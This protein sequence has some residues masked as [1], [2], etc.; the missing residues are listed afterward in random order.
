MM[1]EFLKLLLSLSISGTILILFLFLLKGFMKNKVSKKWQYYIWLIVIARLLIP[2][3]PGMCLVNQGLHKMDFTEAVIRSR[4]AK[5][6]LSQEDK[7][8][9][10]VKQESDPVMA[11]ENFSTRKES[12]PTAINWSVVIQLSLIIIWLAVALIL[13][14]YR[15]NTY[16]RFTRYIKK[17]SA[18][19]IEIEYLELLGKIAENM[20]IKHPIGLFTN[21]FVASAL[22]AGFWKVRIVLPS[23]SL[24]DTELYYTLQHELIHCKRRD[25]FYKWLVQFTICIHWFNP[26]VHVMGQEINHACELSCDEA[27][28][29]KLSYENMRTYGDILL[30]AARTFGKYNN[31]LASVTFIENKKLLKERLDSI[32]N[33]HNKSRLMKGIMFF[34]TVILCTG[35]LGLGAYSFEKPVKALAKMDVRQTSGMAI[36]NDKAVN[37]KGTVSGKVLTSFDNNKM[38][39]KYYK[40]SYVFTICWYRNKKNLDQYAEK[41]DIQLPDQTTMTVYFDNSSKDDTKNE[42]IRSA[43]TKLLQQIKDQPEEHWIVNTNPIVTQTLYVGTDLQQ[44][45]KKYYTKDDI[46]VFSA[47]SDEL[48]SELQMQYCKKAFEDKKINFFSLLYDNLN[49]EELKEYAKKSYTEDRIGFFTLLYDNLDRKELTE[50]AKKA[51]ADNRINY[52]SLLSDYLGKEELTEL[53]RKTYADNRMNYFTLLYDNL[54]KKELAELAKKA[55]TDNRMNYFSILSDYLSKEELAELARKTYA[56]NRMNYFTLLYDNL[57][58]KELTELARKAYTDNKMNYFSL[59]YDNLDKKELAELAKKAFADDRMNYFSLLYDNLN[60]NELKELAKKAYTDN[61]IN[62]FT[63]LYDNLSKEELKEYAKKAFTDGKI[64]FMNILMNKSK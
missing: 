25:M 18:E 59:L 43:L 30:N 38:T 50:L 39:R 7:T 56:D 34:L 63:L 2:F 40:D 46:G 32:M 22:Q 58:K 53:A 45:A 33:Y 4:P 3:A 42:T 23:L 60:K 14:V 11:E 1:L 15:V 13:F 19:V 52:F 62:Y 12:I 55:F 6:L 57:S 64:N 36:L 28:I 51:Y 21:K 20:N 9:G 24:T 31:V 26:F 49:K 41:T 27:V 48:N 16:H 61:K 10:K 54:S 17:E 47:V 37:S 44:I 29:K 5:V 8:Y 35:A